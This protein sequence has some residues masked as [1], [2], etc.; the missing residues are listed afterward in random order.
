[1]WTMAEREKIPFLAI[2]RIVRPQGRRGE[3]VAEI[4]S[5]FSSRFQDLLRRMN[6]PP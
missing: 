5:D 4:L 6:F 2:A 3:V 1:M